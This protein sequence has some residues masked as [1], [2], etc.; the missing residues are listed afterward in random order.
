MQTTFHG[1]H[2]QPAS[3]RL[4]E[5]QV[6]GYGSPSAPRL[7]MQF[8][9]DFGATKIPANRRIDFRQFTSRLQFGNIYI[10]GVPSYTPLSLSERM[11][12]YNG[13]SVQVEFPTTPAVIAA[14]E[15]ERAGGNVKATVWAYLEYEDM[16]LVGNDPQDQQ[17]QVW[18]VARRDRMQANGTAEFSA[19]AWTTRVLPQVGYGVVHVLEFP[20]APL[21][22][23]EGFADSFK[24]LKQAQERH[25]AGLYDDAASK[26][27]IALDKFFETVEVD[28]G[29]GGKKKRPK[30]KAS[31]ETRLGKATYEWLDNALG[32][33]KGATNTSHHSPNEHFDQLES[34]ILI[35]ITT[36]LVAYTARSDPLTQGKPK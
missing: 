24:A 34:Q 11:P 10:E 19:S 12:S 22:Q 9:I 28:D 4:D 23:Y 5:S 18:G 29:K 31:W 1:N 6:N 16:R 27:R 26:C 3:L 8:Q 14:I 33:L 17:A 20:A 15:R 32:A 21:E 13:Y 25:A 2:S 7:M 36:S 35:A 30:L